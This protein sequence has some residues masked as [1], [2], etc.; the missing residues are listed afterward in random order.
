MGEKIDLRTFDTSGR[1]ICAEQIGV[2]KPIRTNARGRR[3]IGC[4]T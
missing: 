1:W 2:Y 3:T 4:A